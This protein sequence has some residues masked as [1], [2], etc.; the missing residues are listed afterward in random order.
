MNN[1][2]SVN[3]MLKLLSSQNS[4]DR[5]HND[6]P[7]WYECPQFLYV[8]PQE[9]L[10]NVQRETI[11]TVFLDPWEEYYEK[12]SAT[13]THGEHTE[14]TEQT[15]FS[16]RIESAIIGTSICDTIQTS[17]EPSIYVDHELQPAEQSQTQTQWQSISTSSVAH[18]ESHLSNEHWES[19]QTATSEQYQ[20]NESHQHEHEHIH[21]EHHHIHETTA[22]SHE[23]SIIESTNECS[24]PQAEPVTDPI[25]HTSKTPDIPSNDHFVS[26]SSQIGDHS[27]SRSD[28]NTDQVRN[29]FVAISNVPSTQ[30]TNKR[31]NSI[32]QQTEPLSLIIPPLSLPRSLGIVDYFFLYIVKW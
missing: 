1:S 4:N 9:Y 32:S 7:R 31:Q 5:R 21:S 22:N 24:L 15:V 29:T 30:Q 26:S 8:P 25:V 12:Q 27:E 18:H 17:S 2:S 10:T 20:S 14:Q 13:S 23:S 6:A 11:D 3:R 19:A 28:D 16:E